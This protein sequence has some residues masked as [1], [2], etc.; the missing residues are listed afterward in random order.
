MFLITVSKMELVMSQRI[1][2]S[3]DPDPVQLCPRCGRTPCVC[4]KIDLS[5]RQQTAYVQRDRKAPRR[6]N[7]NRYFRPTAYAGEIQGPAKDLADRL[8]HRRHGQGG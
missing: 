5:P 8:W 6:Q 7:S 4:Q 3:T 2:Y 1:V